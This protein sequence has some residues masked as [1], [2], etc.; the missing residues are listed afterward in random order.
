MNADGRRWGERSGT[1]NPAVKGLDIEGLKKY[2]GA[3][4]RRRYNRRLHS[5]FHQRKVLA[6]PGFE[7]KLTVM[8]SG[9]NRKRCV[10]KRKFLA[11]KNLC[12][13]RNGCA[14]RHVHGKRFLLSPAMNHRP[15]ISDRVALVRRSIR[16]L[17][18]PNYATC[19]K[20]TILL[21]QLSRSLATW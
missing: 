17:E 10:L 8:F 14:I 2:V 4:P 20:F 11:T 1:S 16:V 19:S 9:G 15:A 18:L 7:E 13:M 21:M 5:P 12:E 6:H 3:L